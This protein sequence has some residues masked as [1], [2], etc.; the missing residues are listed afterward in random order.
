MGQFSSYEIFFSRIMD[1]YEFY[2]G[3]C[4]TLQ[5]NVSVLCVFWSFLFLFVSA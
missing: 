1:E 3:Q 5:Q 4:Y 2:V